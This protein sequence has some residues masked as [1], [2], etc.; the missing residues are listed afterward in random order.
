MIIGSGVIVYSTKKPTR[1][2]YLSTTTSSGRITIVNPG[3][4]RFHVVGRGGRGREGGRARTATDRTGWATGSGGASGSTGAY[5]IQEV[6]LKQ[7]TVIDVTVTALET[8]ASLPL[9]VVAA[10][11]V[12]GTPGREM[13]NQASQDRA[14]DPVYPKSVSGVIATGGNVLNHNGVAGEGSRRSGDAYFRGGRGLVITNSL[15]I[16]TPKTPTQGNAES[17]PL[18][19][20]GAGAGGN[21]ADTINTEWVSGLPGGTGGAGGVVLERG[22][23]K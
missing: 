11:G 7:G 5:A 9:P 15:A 23:Y 17:S 14:A 19:L 13:Y 12:E 10:A 6:Y 1:W 22:V 8:K 3:W 21:G 4:Y 2:E 16:Y 18:L 20:G